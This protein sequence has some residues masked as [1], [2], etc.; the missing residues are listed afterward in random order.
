M[1]IQ[2]YIIV[3][4]KTLNL[5]EGEVISLFLNNKEISKDTYTYENTT[6][7]FSD[8]LFNELLNLEICINIESLKD[9]FIGYRSDSVY[10]Y[11]SEDKVLDINS[12]YL[13]EI[14]L[15]DMQKEHEIKTKLEPAFCK[16]RDVET[17]IKPVINLLDEDDF[18]LEYEIFLSSC[19]IKDTILS[20]DENDDEED[21]KK[22]RLITK[23]TANKVAYDLI[24]RYYY[25]LIERFGTKEMKVG[26]LSEERTITALKLD[27][28]LKRFARNIESLEKAITGEN[29]ITSFVKAKKHESPLKTRLWEQKG[30]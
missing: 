30:N 17:L 3:S 4:E 11:Y 6:I 1:Q 24:A 27:D 28:L 22:T 25:S 12:I 2:K 20:S 9:T 29:I 21:K 5:D 18:D 16:P 14:E 10:K 8:Q 23:L 7:T 15:P 19:D 13:L 26:S